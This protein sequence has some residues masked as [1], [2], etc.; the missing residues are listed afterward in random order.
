VTAA[1]STVARIY[2][3]SSLFLSAYAPLAIIFAMRLVSKQHPIKAI[4]STVI[5][6]LFA[7]NLVVVLRWMRSERGDY[8]AASVESGTGELAGYTATYILPFVMVG[9]VTNWDL[10]AYAV[11]MLI[12]GIICVHGRYLHLN[13]L[14]ALVGYRVY[15]IA[16]VKGRKYLALARG[17]DLFAG[18]AIVA[19]RILD[20]LL[21]VETNRSALAR[22]TVS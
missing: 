8:I 12:L 22:N 3:L 6:V 13:P 18:D 9:D 4:V 17:D 19:R 2:G 16:T 21:I 14:L 15:T 1:V 5:A 10:S 7:L 11:F 20:R